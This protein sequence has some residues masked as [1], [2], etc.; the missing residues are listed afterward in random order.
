MCLDMINV[1]VA[2]V[3]RVDNLRAYPRD[4]IL[5][6][7]HNV[8]QGHCIEPVIGQLELEQFFHPKRMGNL[9]ASLPEA[10]QQIPICHLRTLASRSDPL[11]QDGHV[12]FMPLASQSRNRSAAPKNFIIRMG[13]DNQKFPQF[14]S[15]AGSLHRCLQNAW[16][17]SP[18]EPVIRMK[19]QYYTILILKY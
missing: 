18:P 15:L 17:Q 10:L 9:S 13:S 7:L 2:P 12:N 3:V 11:S 16:D 14:V 1:E 6:N 19:D 8:Q 4:Q 5:Y